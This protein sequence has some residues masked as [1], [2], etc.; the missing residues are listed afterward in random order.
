MLEPKQ[1]KTE[2]DILNHPN[3]NYRK[4]F[5]RMQKERDMKIARHFGNMGA[6][7]EGLMDDEML[8]DILSKMEL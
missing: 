6:W 1:Q 7:K 2:D 8:E 3:G 4:E 5:L